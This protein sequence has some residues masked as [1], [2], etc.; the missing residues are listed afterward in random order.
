[1][2]RQSGRLKSLEGSFVISFNDKLSIKHVRCHFLTQDDQGK[3]DGILDSYE[4]ISSTVA[5]LFINPSTELKLEPKFHISDPDF[6]INIPVYITSCTNGE[7]IAD[8][9]DAKDLCKCKFLFQQ[10]VIEPDEHRHIPQAMRE[11]LVCTY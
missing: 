5:V 4:G 11:G 9:T 10:N 1:M 2:L 6:S 7:K 3:L 8:L